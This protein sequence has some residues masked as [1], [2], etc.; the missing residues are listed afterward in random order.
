MKSIT[1]TEIWEMI[2]L[3]VS[4]CLVDKLKSRCNCRIG[5][6]IE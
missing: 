6:L 5:L 3:D 2:K 1:N 4:E